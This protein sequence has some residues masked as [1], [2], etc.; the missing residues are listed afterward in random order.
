MR[1]IEV[2]PAFPVRL[3]KAN[4][5][6]RAISKVP[7]LSSVSFENT[8]GEFIVTMIFFF[9]D[10]PWFEFLIIKFKILQLCA[11]KQLHSL[12]PEF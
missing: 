9:D 2:I 1:H 6:K 10:F 8:V 11:L 12:G 3:T 7:L 5:G 4:L